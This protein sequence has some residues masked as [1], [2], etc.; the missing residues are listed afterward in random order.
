MCVCVCVC[1]SVTL[2]RTGRTL[3]KI[4]NVENNV[5]LFGVITKIVFRDLNLHFQ[6]Q[7]FKI[8]E[9]RFGKLP[10][11]KNMK[12]SAIHIQIFEIERRKCG[13]SPL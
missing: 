5:C 12:N 11:A 7:M 4:K 3:A 13:I 6:F 10:E 8:W 1:L 9:I 2:L